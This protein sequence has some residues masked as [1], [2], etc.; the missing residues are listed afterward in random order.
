MRKSL[1]KWLSVVFLL[2]LAILLVQWR[3]NAMSPA[4]FANLPMN[5]IESVEVR[6]CGG[7]PYALPH[8][9]WPE[10]LAKIGHATSYPFVGWNG[11]SWQRFE[12]VE[13]AMPDR[14]RYALEFATRPSLNGTVF[15]SIE[16]LEG[17]GFSVYGHYRSDELQAW[18]RQRLHLAQSDV[19]AKCDPI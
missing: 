7:T 14:G 3:M 4:D 15:F 19:K 2:V 8:D 13:I 6:T 12:I 5:A 18:L 17:S 10:L 9:D 11:E 16:R 1:T